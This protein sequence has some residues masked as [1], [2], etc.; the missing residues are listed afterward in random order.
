MDVVSALRA[1]GEAGAQ[2]VDLLYGDAAHDVVR[3]LDEIAKSAKKESGSEAVQNRLSLATNILGIGAGVAG[4]RG[5]MSN[6]KEKREALKTPAGVPRRAATSAPKAPKEVKGV[7]KPVATVGRKLATPKGALAVAGGLTALQGAN[8][9]GDFITNR[10]VSRA[11][12]RRKEQEG[13]AKSASDIEWTGEIAKADLD[14]RQVFGWASVTSIDGVSVNDLQEDEIDLAEIEKAAYAYVQESR[15]GGNMHARDGESPK[16][17][18]K[19]IESFVVSKDKREKLGLPD[20]VPDGW[21]VGFQVE[22]EDTWQ[23]VKNDELTMFSIH[24][25]GRRT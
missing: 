21:W 14:K 19:L 24:G 16:V 11:E 15:L 3:K 9:A 23:Q 22:D 8:L 17:V 1:H 20:T 25:R 7:F 2:I 10:V 4:L 12:R 6:L 13:V 5:E 18:S